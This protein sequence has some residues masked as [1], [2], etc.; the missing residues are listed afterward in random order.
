MMQ[1]ARCQ[2]QVMLSR[3][4]DNAWR[5]PCMGWTS[6]AKESCGRLLRPACR[7]RTRSAHKCCCPAH[8]CAHIQLSRAFECLQ[9]LGYLTNH[10]CSAAGSKCNTGSDTEG[11]S[12]M[13]GCALL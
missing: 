8:V 6:R 13:I 12:Y 10:K 11:F 2:F 1:Q 3:H 5:C 7:R 9:E 4:C